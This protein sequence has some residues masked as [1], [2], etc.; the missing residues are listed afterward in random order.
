MSAPA[1]DSP[2]VGR[3]TSAAVTS[4]YIVAAKQRFALC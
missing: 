1:L 2:R 4:G 3:L